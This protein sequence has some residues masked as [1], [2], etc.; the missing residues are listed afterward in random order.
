MGLKGRNL[1]PFSVKLSILLLLGSFVAIYSSAVWASEVYI[2]PLEGRSG[3][4]IEVPI[5]IDRVDN[6]AGVKLVMTY[7]KNILT[8]KK[9]AKTEQTDSLMHIINDKRP[10]LLIFVLA[11]AKG[12][13][14]KK[15]PIMKLTFEIKKGLKGNRKSE[16]KIK[17][18][19]LMSD[20]LKNIESKTVS[21]PI[22]IL[23]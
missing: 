9:G 11:G 12:I 3:Q 17:E 5:M 19:Q 1:K 14:G 23:P 2:P 10:G 22:T 13:K 20:K 21:N 7:D 8:F 4:S 18:V 6:L 15:F 16:I